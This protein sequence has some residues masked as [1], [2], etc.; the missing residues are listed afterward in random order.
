MAT[1]IF[2]SRLIMIS[3]LR[4]HR[5]G[6]DNIPGHRLQTAVSDGMMEYESKGWVKVVAYLLRG[7]GV[8]VNRAFGR[9]FAYKNSLLYERIDDRRRP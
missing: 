1:F 7:V 2:E 9:L 3:P 6:L 4:M 5:T 8:E